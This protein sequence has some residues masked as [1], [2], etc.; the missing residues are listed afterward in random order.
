[1]ARNVPIIP[2]ETHGKPVAELADEIVSVFNSKGF[3]KKT[4]RD[5][6]DS[7]MSPSLVFRAEEGEFFGRKG[8]F[9]YNHISRMTV[10]APFNGDSM[11]HMLLSFVEERFV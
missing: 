8:Q 7:A 11:Q 9:I 6:R 2:V 3:T 1:M 5:W 10:F 4:Y